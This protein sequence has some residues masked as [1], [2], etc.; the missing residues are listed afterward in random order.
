MPAL[1]GASAARAARL[2]GL[3]YPRDSWWAR[4]GAPVLNV[5]LRFRYKAFRIY[6]HS[7]AEVEGVIRQQGL[8]RRF[9]RY[10]GFWQ[11][12]VYGR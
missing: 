5:F 4:R 10:V 12:A 7:S 11:V 8:E 6:I 9:H 1:V 2:Y 3:V